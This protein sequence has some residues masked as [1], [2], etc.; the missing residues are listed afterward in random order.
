MRR[1]IEPMA[2]LASTLKRRTIPASWLVCPVSLADA[3]SKLDRYWSVNSAQSENSWPSGCGSGF[4]AHCE[5]Q[6]NIAFCGT[7]RCRS[8]ANKCELNHQ[9]AFSDLPSAFP[10]SDRRVLF[11][12]PEVTTLEAA[13]GVEPSDIYEFRT[14]VFDAALQHL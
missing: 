3:S 1:A 5:I 13:D 2:S 9:S 4:I 12:A 7:V 10:Y 8:D 6:S 14:T 11:S